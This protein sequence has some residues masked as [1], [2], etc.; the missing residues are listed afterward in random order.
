MTKLHRVIIAFLIC[1]MPLCF[2][3][4]GGR[5]STNDLIARAAMRKRNSGDEPRETAKKPEPSEKKTQQPQSPSPETAT[6]TSPAAGAKPDPAEVKTPTEVLKTLDELKVK[7]ISER[8]PDEEIAEDSRRQ[9]AVD[10]LLK[11][12]E[13]LEK[14]HETN[15]QY[16]NRFHKTASGVGTLSWRV[17]LLPYLGY[18]ALH[19]KFDFSRPWNFEPNKSLLQYIPDVYVSPER[20]DTKTNYLLPAYRTFIFGNEVGGRRKHDVDKEDGSANTIL[21]VEVNDELAV[22]WTKPDDYAPK[23]LKTISKDIGELRGDGAFA[24]WANGWPVLL[25]NSLSTTQLINA[26]TFDAGDGQLAGEVHR[27]IPVADMDDA[28]MATAEVVASVAT[29]TKSQSTNDYPK[30]VADDV[31]REPLPI[32]A[33]IA[34]AQKRLRQIFITKIAEAKEDDEKSKLSQEML[35]D[36]SSMNADPA[37][38]Y[39]LQTAAM[40]LATDAGEFNDVLQAV[41]QRVGRFEVNSYEENVTAL[42]KFAEGN[43]KRDPDD[44][45]GESFLK[46]AV[47]V[48][49]AAIQDDDYVRASGICRHAYRI[50]DQ[51]PTEDIQKSLNRL[52]L[53]LASAQRE[54]DKA[55]KHLA[56]YRE[57]P[58]QVEDAAAFGRF[59]CFIKGDWDRGLPLM[60]MGGPKNLKDVAEYDL[61]GS[62]TTDEEVAMG[63]RW[64]DL[65]I[66]IR[67]GVYRQAAQDRAS[68]WYGRAFP[69]MAD[70]LDRI[71][72]KNR[73]AELEE[74]DAT[75]PLALIIQLA[76]DVGVNLNASLASIADVGQQRLTNNDDD[77]D[78]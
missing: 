15:G 47:P 3:G 66:A 4:C 73:I 24:V 28:E 67:N 44:M 48:V 38:A 11:I 49:F 65:S 68:Y 32:A 39:V 34:K 69:N 9:N 58:E 40:K 74:S 31:V 77:D 42:L 37:G 51:E 25:A 53:L 59:L 14:Y 75:S 72:V 7:P 19:K 60:V 71:H 43:T 22:P 1:F 18:E 6:N 64:W 36:A 23:N 26:F 50:R 70:S 46:R 12:A 62:K 10:N 5:P 56:F 63:D 45:D 20:Y 52:R 17:E 33:E 8:K 27:D 2:V 21:L 13:A 29:E 41:D 16:P 78:D 57:D 61:Q 35:D 54:Y 30:P 55:A 76:E